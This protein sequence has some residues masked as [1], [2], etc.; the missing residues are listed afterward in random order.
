MH[1]KVLGGGMEPHPME[2]NQFPLDRSLAEQDSLAVRVA[3]PSLQGA[4]EFKHS[5]AVNRDGWGQMMGDTNWILQKIV[6]HL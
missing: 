3:Q 5:S 1:Q 6:I 2:P 4:M